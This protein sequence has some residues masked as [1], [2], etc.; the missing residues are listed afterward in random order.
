MSLARL[1]SVKFP[2]HGGRFQFPRH[3]ADP[4]DIGNCPDHA[5]RGCKPFIRRRRHRSDGVGRRLCRLVVAHVA[6]RLAHVK[7]LDNLPLK[8]R[9]TRERVKPCPPKWRPA[10]EEAMRAVGWLG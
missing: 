10:I 1:R 4:A 2:R 6:E 5:D 9:R 7:E 8:S 3:D